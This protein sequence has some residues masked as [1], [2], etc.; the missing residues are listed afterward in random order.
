MRSARESHWAKE[1]KEKPKERDSKDIV[2]IVGNSVMLLRS[3]HRPKE[4]AKSAK[5]KNPL[6]TIPISNVTLAG[7]GVTLR[8]IAQ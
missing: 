6:G 5:V 1:E 7:S 8:G 4:R 2:L 3:V